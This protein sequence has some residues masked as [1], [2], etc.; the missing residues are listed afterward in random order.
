MCVAVIDK[1]H[2]QVQAF[3]TSVKLYFI[4]KIYIFG[5]RN[6]HDKVLN[7]GEFYEVSSNQWT[8]LKESMKYERFG[9]CTFILWGKFDI[10]N[11][12][13]GFTI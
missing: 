7:T 12:L 10:F 4:E 9:L 3:I 6:Q 11:F 5:G 8:T 2:C 1:D 13:F